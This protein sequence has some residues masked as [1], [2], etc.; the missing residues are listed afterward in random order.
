MQFS[1]KLIEQEKAILSEVIRTQKDIVC[2]HL[3]VDISFKVN[4][5]HAVIH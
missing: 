1:G 5:N 3:E 2:T 4:D